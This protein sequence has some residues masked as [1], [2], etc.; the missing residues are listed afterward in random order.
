[1]MPAKMG[2]F[3]ESWAQSRCRMGAAFSLTT[4][5]IENYPGVPVSGEALV[6]EAGV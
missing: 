1:M 2:V 4:G 6:K 5:M 3:A